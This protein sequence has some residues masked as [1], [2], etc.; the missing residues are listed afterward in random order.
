MKSRNRVTSGTTASLSTHAGGRASI[1]I[2]RGVRPSRVEGC[3]RGEAGRSLVEGPTRTAQP[4]PP[5]GRSTEPQGGRPRGARAETPRGSTSFL[6]AEHIERRIVL[7]RGEKVLLDSD[8]AA[9]YAVPTKALNQAVRRNRDRFPADFAFQLTLEEAREASRSQFVT[10]K[11]GGNLKYRPLAFTEQGVAMLSSVLRSLRAA[12]VNVEIMRAFVRM[13]RL[14]VDRAALWRKIEDLER[15]Y[16]RRFRVVFEVLRR[17]MAPPIA[18]EKES[19]LGFRPPKGSGRDRPG[20]R[21]GCTST[22]AAGPEMEE[23]SRASRWKVARPAGLEPAAGGLETH[24]SVRLSYGRG[25]RD[26]G[27]NLPRRRRSQGGAPVRN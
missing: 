2:A 7:V 12:R 25:R 18:P 24:C 23:A 19:P 20:S 3:R 11:R 17:L 27:K 16:D 21:G 22:A 8:L 4:G 15:R 1:R 14:L 26:L 9:L 6:H 10:L 13:R 5:S